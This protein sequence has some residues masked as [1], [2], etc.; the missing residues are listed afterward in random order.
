MHLYRPSHSLRVLP[1]LLA[2]LLLCA[3]TLQD[4][5]T[6][7]GTVAASSRLH[8]SFVID[9]LPRW[10]LPAG[11]RLRLDAANTIV[12]PAWQ[13]GAA[14]ALQPWLSAA[15]Q[16]GH[17]LAVWWPAATPED[18]RES[19]Q[20]QINLHPF[21]V[22]EI[23]RI[24]AQRVIRLQLFDPSGALLA[25]PTITLRARMFDEVSTATITDAFAELARRLYRQ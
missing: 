15:E 6:A 1:A 3:C 7:A 22:R 5:P 25:A 11:A 12:H 10:R 21:G 20:H 16:G 9:D 2:P 8:T 14:E 19:W 4:I 17:R 18:Q 13:D 24:E 23:P